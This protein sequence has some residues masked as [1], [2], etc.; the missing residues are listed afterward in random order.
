MGALERHWRQQASPVH[1]LPSFLLCAFLGLVCVAHTLNYT[2]PRL[3]QLQRTGGRVLPG[4][5]LLSKLFFLTVPLSESLW[6]QNSRL[7]L[8]GLIKPFLP[9]HFCLACV[10]A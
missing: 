10:I 6:S 7:T 8:Q 4:Q 1:A 5:L 2:L 3:L 9:G